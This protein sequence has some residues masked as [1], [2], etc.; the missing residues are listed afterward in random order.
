MRPSKRKNN[1]MRGVSI[2]TSVLNSCQASCIIKVGSTHVICSAVFEKQVPRFLKGS[3]TGW[4][5]AEYGMLPCSGSQRIKREAASGKQT[6]R[7]Q[8]IQRLIGRSLRAAVDLRAMG[9]YQVL[10]DCDVINA[11]GGTRTASIT[12]GYVAMHLLFKYMLKKGI[13]EKNP[14]KHQIAAVSCGIYDGEVI[15]DLD[16]VEDSNAQMDA[17]FIFTA[18]GLIVEM[19]AAAEKSPVKED[20][21]SEM[22]SYAKNAIPILCNVQMEALLRSEK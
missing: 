16:Y 12:G 3:G 5:T 2:E 20:A 11:D 15:V 13:L 10:I 22:L 4:I 19:Q 17:N 9:E 1:E 7:T 14:I 6:G 18:E 21:L 8:E